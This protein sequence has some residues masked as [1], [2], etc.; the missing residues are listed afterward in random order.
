MAVISYAKPGRRNMEAFLRDFDQSVGSK[1]GEKRFGEIGDL[2]SRRRKSL[3]SLDWILWSSTDRG[4]NGSSTVELT[5]HY[6][7]SSGERRVSNS[8]E[9]AGN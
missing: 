4:Q 8:L 5:T 1:L 6:G 7:K 3:E 9:N 2:Y